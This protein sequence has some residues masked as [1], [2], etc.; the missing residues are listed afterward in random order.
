[1]EE[2]DPQFDPEDLKNRLKKLNEKPV[3]K[4]APTFEKVYAAYDCRVRKLIGR[5]YDTLVLLDFN[6][7]PIINRFKNTF[8]NILKKTVTM[9]MLIELIKTS[10]GLFVKTLLTRGTTLYDILKVLEQ[11]GVI[12]LVGEGTFHEKTI[13]PTLKDSKGRAQYDNDKV[14]KVKELLEMRDLDFLFGI[15]AYDLPFCSSTVDRSAYEVFLGNVL[16]KAIATHE[17][18]KQLA[19]NKNHQFDSCEAWRYRVLKESIP[20]LHQVIEYFLQ[21]LF[22][23]YKMIDIVNERLSTSVIT[24]EGQQDLE[25]NLEQLVKK[26]MRWFNGEEF[27]SFNKFRLLNTTNDERMI[28]ASHEDLNK[29]DVEASR[30]ILNQKITWLAKFNLYAHNLAMAVEIFSIPLPDYCEMMRMLVKQL[31]NKDDVASA[32]KFCVNLTDYISE[33]GLF[34]EFLKN[35]EE[36]YQKVLILARELL[37]ILE[38]K[39]ARTPVKYGRSKDS[40]RNTS[41]QNSPRNGNNLN[42]ERLSPSGIPRDEL[43]ERL[44]ALMDTGQVKETS[45][46]KSLDFGKVKPKNSVFFRQSS[47]KSLELQIEKQNDVTPKVATDPSL[48]SGEMP[49]KKLF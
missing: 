29:D 9:E 48:D 38:E 13:I 43:L 4:K 45:A 23:I 41:T 33:F 30:N 39:Q 46:K 2:D 6:Q 21:L 11:E 1:M 10:D 34:L 20:I 44:S 15:N 37:E 26:I 18:F 42:R 47:E 31:K 19:T 24:I 32:S 36:P 35:K 12:K 40:S 49:S 28:L 3:K 8:K 25:T 7:L 17:D 14:F 16:K 5:L 22:C 27:K